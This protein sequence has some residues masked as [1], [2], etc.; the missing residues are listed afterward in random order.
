MTKRLAEAFGQIDETSSVPVNEAPAKRV[1]SKAMKVNTLTAQ[2]NVPREMVNSITD[3]PALRHTIWQLVTLPTDPQS[4]RLLRY[5]IDKGWRKIEV[6]GKT[7]MYHA[8]SFNHLEGAKLPEWTLYGVYSMFRPRDSSDVP[9]R[10]TTTSRPEMQ[11]GFADDIDQ[12]LLNQ[13]GTRFVDDDMPMTVTQSE[14]DK[15]FFDFISGRSSVA[16]AEQAADSFYQQTGIVLEPLTGKLKRGEPT[17]E[18]QKPQLPGGVDPEDIIVLAEG[19]SFYA[20]RAKDLDEE[21]IH[22]SQKVI[23]SGKVRVDSQLPTG[24]LAKA[25]AADDDN[26]AWSALRKRHGID[27]T[28]PKPADP[29]QPGRGKSDMWQMPQG[30]PKKDEPRWVQKKG[31]FDPVTGKTLDNDA[32]AMP[33]SAGGQRWWKDEKDIGQPVQ[34]PS[35]WVKGKQPS[36]PKDE[37]QGEVE[38]P[39]VKI[40][41]DGALS[42]IVDLARKEGR[43]QIFLLG[44]RDSKERTQII[45]RKKTRSLP[46]INTTPVSLEYERNGRISEPE[47]VQRSVEWTKGLPVKAGKWSVDDLQKYLRMFER[48]TGT[49]L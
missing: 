2:R 14:P 8:R 17:K 35:A 47:K 46:S 4:S 33:K 22:D 11:K 15:S 32:P 24:A 38:R 12:G 21:V 41:G 40:R 9:K 25:T 13:W 20:I 36:P 19:G 6:Q 10:T 28:D 37:P 31:R 3:N 44:S 49:R 42:D 43:K 39:T 30:E 16:A 45:N 48:D 18:V 1:K 27:K 7:L 23:K 29:E 5:M 34:I 26:D